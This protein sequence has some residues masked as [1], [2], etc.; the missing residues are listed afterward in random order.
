MIHPL[1]G[2]FKRFLWC[3]AGGRKQMLPATESQ[4]LRFHPTYMTSPRLEAYVGNGVFLCN[5]Y[6]ADQ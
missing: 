3:H 5:R 6:D 4:R 1:W 2:A